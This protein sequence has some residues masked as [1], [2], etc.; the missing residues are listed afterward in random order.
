MGLHLRGLA[1]TIVDEP[2]SISPML[3]QV[4]LNG[5]DSTQNVA[6]RSPKQYRASIARRPSGRPLVNASAS[7]LQSIT[8]Q[9]SLASSFKLDSNTPRV[10]SPKV[11]G[12]TP[13]THHHLPSS[14]HLVSQ[15]AAWLHEEKSKRTAR[16][17]TAK[18][19]PI[20]ASAPPSS[21]HASQDHPSGLR[22]RRSSD[23][24]DEGISL[25]KL[26]QILAEHS[27]VDPDHKQQSSNQERRGSQFSRR[28]SSIRKLGKGSITAG[29]SDTEYQD[30]DALVSTA[31][32]F[33]D[34]S[35]TLSYFSG[36]ADTE[37]DLNI[38]SKRAAK[39]GWL[40]FKHEILRLAHTL[41]LKGW[42]RVP[43]DRSGDIDVERLSGALTNAVYVVS[44]P[45]HL[46][47]TPTDKDGSRAPLAPKKP[48]P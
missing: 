22:A 26:E 33:L 4:P 44:P 27:V 23:A 29:S 36:A 2:E 30:G 13:Q 25:E 12:A 39:E 8:S 17:A 45:K 46:E 19:L 11:D 31:E 16:K 20:F 43:L 35:K 28:P 14:K 1:V 15:I 32:V 10:D 7:S 47:Q 9:S 6:P 21:T 48:P 34:N 18:G 3:P 42:R 24:S 5:D 41:R 40:T 38:S 37:P